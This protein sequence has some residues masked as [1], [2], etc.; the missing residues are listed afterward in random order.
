[1]AAID[2]GSTQRMPYISVYHR[3]HPSMH[4]NGQIIA[5]GMAI[6]AWSKE[7]WGWGW[8]GEENAEEQTVCAGVL[9]YHVIPNVYICVRVVYTTL[10]RDVTT[11]AA[12]GLLAILRSSQ[13]ET[14]RE[15][16]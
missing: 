8:G 7:G 6:A 2:V 12:E 13:R 5:M 14:R 9:V 4:T 15:K 10:L 1:M 11:L 3:M 16:K